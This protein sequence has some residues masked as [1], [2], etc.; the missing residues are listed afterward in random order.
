MNS[1]IVISFDSGSYRVDLSYDRSARSE[2]LNVS[3]VPPARSVNR[4]IRVSYEPA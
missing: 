3:P 1:G 4:A 2:F